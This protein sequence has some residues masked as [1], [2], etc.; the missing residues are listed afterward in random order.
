M[1]SVSNR[2]IIVALDG[3]TFDILKPMVN[4]GELPH[5]AALMSE[6][7]YERL[8]ST[9]PS[10]TGPAFVTFM[11]GNNPGRH[12]I[13]RFVKKS[14]NPDKATLLNASHIATR[15]IWEWL[16]EH[17]KK[18]IVVGVPF[19][20]PPMPINGVMVSSQ[21]LGLSGFRSV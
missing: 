13:T 12:G 17:G 14:I 16:S 11:T 7:S 10:E 3:A 21:R 6:G 19:T 20:Y 5:L 18:S 1:K 9:I 8:L 15:T 2:I 4:R